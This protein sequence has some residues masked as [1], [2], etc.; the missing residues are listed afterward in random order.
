MPAPAIKICGISTSDT[1]AAVIAARAEHVGF[2]FHA[3]SPR[4]VT[5]A[6]AQALGAQAK[7]RI[8]RV[9][10]FVDA[11]DAA[12][13]EAVSTGAIDVLQLHGDESPARVAEL[14]NRFGL[15]VW[16]VIGVAGAPDLDRAHNY[17]GAAD[18]V[19]LD[20]RTPAGSLP[21]GM[22]LKFDWGLLA[23]WKAPLP[24]G[25]AGGLNPGNVAEAIAATG[26]P[27]VDAASG[28]ERAKGVKDPALIAQFCAAVRNA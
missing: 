3:P 17:V 16:K 20:A 4:C 2:N 24:W 21:G 26:A 10:L 27:L 28:V 14:R 18:L 9:G 22:G 8:G 15:P 1:L 7:G 5:I 11:P 12:L 19:L 13:D 6:Q 23:Q 25:L